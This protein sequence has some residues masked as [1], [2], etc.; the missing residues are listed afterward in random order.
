MWMASLVAALIVMAPV[1]AVAVSPAA[2]VGGTAATSPVP[3]PDPSAPAATPHPST[4]WSIGAATPYG[5]LMR[6]VWIPPQPVVIETP[7]AVTEG[8][9]L[10]SQQQVVQVPGYYASETTLGVY[11]P[12]RWVIERV[13]PAAYRWR[14][15]AA[16][17]RRR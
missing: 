12:E 5:Q 1:M 17:F 14:V 8:E 13:G 4:P 7:L 15:A 9:R 11:Y 10:G 16:E 3:L 6:Y 2:G